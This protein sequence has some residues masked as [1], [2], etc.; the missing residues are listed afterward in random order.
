MKRVLIV[1]DSSLFRKLLAKAI[2]EDGVTIDMASDG[3]EAIEKYKGNTP[4]LVLL[5]ITMPNCDGKEC[6]TQIMHLNPKANVIMI[7]GIESEE[8][9]AE[10]L[11]IG[12]K[13]YIPKGDLA[14]TKVQST[15]SFSQIV[16]QILGAKEAA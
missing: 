11:R 4:D 1:D 9:V 2:E 12:A 5:D 16:D 8:T 15:Q 13:G 10:C 7:S 14:I 6:L 3:L